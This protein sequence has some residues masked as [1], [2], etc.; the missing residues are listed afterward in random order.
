MNH[1][2][3]QD[4]ENTAFMDS[5]YEVVQ[6]KDTDPISR[7][8]VQRVFAIGGQKGM[9]NEEIKQ[10]IKAEGFASVKDI[11]HLLVLFTAV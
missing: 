6:A 5:A 3:T 7:K 11:L 10:F 4:M 1:I 9:T 8:Q 2:F